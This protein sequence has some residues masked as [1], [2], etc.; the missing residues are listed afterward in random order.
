MHSALNHDDIL[1]PPSVEAAV[2]EQEAARV[3]KKAV[4]A[5]RTS[6]QQTLG[7]ALGAV[8]WT[9]RNGST[10]ANAIPRFGKIPSR[11]APGMPAIGQAA[12]GSSCTSTFPI[13]RFGQGDAA[14]I[15]TAAAAAPSS[16]ALIAR[17]RSAA[18]ASAAGSGGAAAGSEGEARGI[19]LAGA[20]KS[21]VESKGGSASTDALLKE[22][23]VQVSAGESPL[24]KA[25]LKQ[26]CVL[27]P[28][29]HGGGKVW[30][31]KPE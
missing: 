9:G 16:A 20:I 4:A 12:K 30:K 14:G 1:A 8:T 31:L 21:F 10:G 5:L 24:F 7:A 15:A 28:K 27:E 6:Q 25:V 26:I 3:A 19:K 22:F 2:A 13:P 23:E 17:I 29:M 11:R 18:S